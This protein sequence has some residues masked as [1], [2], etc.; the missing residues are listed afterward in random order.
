MKPGIITAIPASAVLLYTLNSE[1][2]LLFSLGKPT[3]LFLVPHH[4]HAKDRR[5][6]IA[7]LKEDETEHLWLRVKRYFPD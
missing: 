7:K 2:K 4:E 5:M 1:L 6:R 3:S